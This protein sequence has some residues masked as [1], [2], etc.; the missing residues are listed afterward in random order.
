MD[1]IVND[2]NDISKAIPGPDVGIATNDR[3]DLENGD[4]ESEMIETAMNVS[5]CKQLGAH[6]LNKNGWFSQIWREIPSKFTKL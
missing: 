1:N 3:K 6:D 5:K 4:K 2:C